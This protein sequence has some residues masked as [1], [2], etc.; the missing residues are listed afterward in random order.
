MDPMQVVEE[1]SVSGRLP[2][3]A[4]RTAQSNREA[5]VPAFLRTIDDFLELKGP[6]RPERA[7]PH[8]SFARRVA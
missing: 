5:M 2:V 7:V 1:L 3:E 4:I 6:G 8:F